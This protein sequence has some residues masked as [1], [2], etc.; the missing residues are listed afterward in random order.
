MVTERSVNFWDVKNTDRTKA[1][2]DVNTCNKVIFWL[3][4]SKL[5]TERDTSAKENSIMENS[6][7]NAYS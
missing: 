6:E 7:K 5:Q 1:A 4:F 3:L 2:V